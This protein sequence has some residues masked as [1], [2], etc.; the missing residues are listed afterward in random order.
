[1]PRIF[2]VLA[3]ASA[4]ILF[5][6]P[7]GKAA[8]EGWRWCSDYSGDM[9]GSS[10]CGFE[11]YQQC[12]LNVSGIGGYCRLNPFFKGAAERPARKKRH[13]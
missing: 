4:A 9:G 5:N 12:M 13:D 6:P 10:N 2:I 3:A 7:A 11:T 1:M 8:S